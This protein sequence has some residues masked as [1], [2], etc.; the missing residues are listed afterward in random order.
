MRYSARSGSAFAFHV[1]VAPPR[2]TRPQ[3]KNSDDG[4]HLTRI[5]FRIAVSREQAH[6]SEE[7]IF[8]ANSVGNY[9]MCLPSKRKGGG[10]TKTLNMSPG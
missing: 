9:P 8:C 1:N 10:R 6:P 7:A 2:S 5:D 4:S 3:H